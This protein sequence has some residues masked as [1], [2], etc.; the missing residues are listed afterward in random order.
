MRTAAT[1]RLGRQLL[2]DVDGQIV[3]LAGH[4]DSGDPVDMMPHPGLRR[5]SELDPSRDYEEI[6]RLHA[7]IEF[8]WDIARA[9]EMALY[10]TYCVPSIGSLLHETQEFEQRAQKRYDDTSLL[11]GEALK[12]GLNSER[13]RAAVR[14]INQIHSRF[15]ISNED[16][17]Y[18]LSVFVVVPLR[19]LDRFGWRAV[20]ETER[21]ATYT[22]YREFGRRLGIR[23]IPETREELFA[24][25][26]AYESEHFAHTPA[27]ARVGTATREL[28]VGWFW[29]APA[30]LVRMG[31]H[32]LLDPPVLAAFGF[33]PAPRPVVRAL[34]TALRT[35]ARLVPLLPARRR[36]SY[37]QDSWTVRS[38]PRGYEIGELGPDGSRRPGASEPRVRRATGQG[39]PMGQ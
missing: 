23:D 21:R 4:R 13:G 7:T 29:F 36:P 3:R 16:M 17:L 19:W 25:C 9:L 18:V 1:C 39:T 11:L 20:T 15:S 12:F 27:N 33:P 35:R 26:D 8:P 22:Y 24:F 6:Y 10:R 28:F 30:P 32:A 2:S 38:Y 37:A 31:V 14:R 5:I 34:E